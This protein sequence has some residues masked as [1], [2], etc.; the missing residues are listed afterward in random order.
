MIFVEIF[1]RLGD[2]KA[3]L[4]VFQ[5]GE[6]AFFRVLGHMLK[7][8]ALKLDQCTSM[9]APMRQLAFNQASL[10]KEP[11]LF[12][13]VVLRWKC[14]F[15]EMRTRLLWHS[16]SDIFSAFFQ[17]YV[18]QITT[19]KTTSEDDLHANFLTLMQKE[20]TLLQA[21]AASVLADMGNSA[22][23]T[24]QKHLPDRVVMIDYIFFAPLKENPLLEAKCVVCVNGSMPVMFDLNYK[25]I[26]YQAHLVKKSI[27]LST[28]DESKVTE[29]KIGMELALLAQV[30]FPPS[31]VDILKPQRGS[32][33][34]ISPDSDIVDIPID[35]LPL[36]LG[37]SLPVPLCELFS[38]SI[39]PSMRSLFL[40]DVNKEDIH[41]KVCSIIGNP[42]FNL[43]KSGTEPSIVEKVVSYFSNHFSLSDSSPIVLK[44]L[45]HSQNEIDYISHQ[46][47][48]QGLTVQLL[49][50][51]EANISNVLSIRNPMLLHISSHSSCGTKKISAF[52]GNF[53]DDLWSSAIALA[54][55][56]T[57]S[58][59]QYHQLHADCGPAQLWPLAIFSMKLRGTKLVYLSSCDSGT[60]TAPIQEAVDSLA[61]A[62]LIAGAET[63]VASLWPVD[64]HMASEFSTLF[65]EKLINPSIRPSEALVHARD[66]FKKSSANDQWFCSFVCYG[67]NK[68]LF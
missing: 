1:Q 64:D 4:E 15:K 35:L 10:I 49:V 54:G 67:L 7:T 33:L 26:H 32:Q 45:E 27:S 21:S 18:G 2:D 6:Q 24:L 52:R 43:C 42:N 13:D 31:V 60:G 41:S 30:L 48:S 57:F 39:I 68:P 55:F 46:L 25:A 65:Y 59:Q 19:P 5:K 28:T 16:S 38:V 62:F 40:Y 17:W 53:F 36:S 56:N 50:G 44:Q 11:G 12:A 47:G 22:Y 61:E 63:V 14:L 29:G 3:A 9:I 34:Y 23:S 37:D 20:E 8:N 58:K 66:C 51:N